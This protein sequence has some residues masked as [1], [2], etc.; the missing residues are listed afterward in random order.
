VKAESK[1]TTQRARTHAFDAL[2]VY[3]REAVLAPLDGFA[4]QALAQRYDVD[5]LAAT[6]AVGVET[7]CHRLTALKH[8]PEVPRFGY[9]RA[10]AAGTIVET[11][12]LTGLLTPRYA[13]ACPL[14]VLFRAQQ[15]PDATIRQRAL[16]PSGARYVFVARAGNTGLTGFGRARHYVTDML[17]I[18]EDD[19]AKTIYAPEASVP[20]EAV[21]TACRSCPRKD[22]DHRVADPLAG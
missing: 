10:N 7:V 6:F 14:W 12:S 3:A 13:S 4:A 8:A 5:A 22:C 16:F 17:A 1:L 21:G 2:S 15:S 19:A 9:F 20:V 11:R 18:T